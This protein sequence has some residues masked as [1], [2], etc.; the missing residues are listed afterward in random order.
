M[1]NYYKVSLTT[2]I[3]NRENK[4]IK[5]KTFNK[6]GVSHCTNPCIWL[7]GDYRDVYIYKG[8]SRDNKDYT[9]KEFLRVAAHE[10]GHVLGL[11]DLYTKSSEVKEKYCCSRTRKSL[12]C[13]HWGVKSINGF[14][15]KGVIK[16]FAKNRPYRWE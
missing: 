5:I 6:R 4:A 14:D 10:F 11:D 9:A 12:M 3:K 2:S 1:F 16:A 7:V 8:D 13:E 15:L